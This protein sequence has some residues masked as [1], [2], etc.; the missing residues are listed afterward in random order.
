[1]EMAVGLPVDQGLQLG[2]LETG[3]PAAQPPP[4]TLP[5]ASLG[6]PAGPGPISILKMCR[7]CGESKPRTD[8]HRNHSKADEL[9]D[10]CRPCKAQR[11]AARRAIRASVGPIILATVLPTC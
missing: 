6:P 11:D 8:Y 5:E 9:E 10:V 1:M 4:V 3:A 2:G 7:N